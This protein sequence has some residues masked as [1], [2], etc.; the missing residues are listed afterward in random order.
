MHENDL[1][2][3]PEIAERVIRRQ[4]PQWNHERVQW[5]DTAGTVNVIVRI[6]ENMAARFRRQ[7]ADPKEVTEDLRQET[8]ALDELSAA[9]S[10]AV[11]TV[12]AIGEPSPEY[13]L[14]WSIQTWVPGEITTP[15]NVADSQ[16]FCDDLVALI[17]EFRQTDTQGRQFSGNGRGGELRSHDEWMETCFRRSEGLLDVPG[18]R[19]L[20]AQFREL[21][22]QEPDVMAH[23]DLI[24]GNLLTHGGRMA[25]LL[26][27]GSFGPADPAL[28][29]VSAWHLLDSPLHARLR[30]SLGCSELQWHRGAAWAFQQAMGLVWYYNN[31]NPVMR[32]LGR[33]TLTRIQSDPELVG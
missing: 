14:P 16:R 24:P 32:D 17:K 26:D 25:G 6:G 2:L 3:T 10:V 21:P 9:V 18:L 27:G 13:P 15:T 22:H 31:T 33:S 12:V 20:W 28:D 7:R 30:D 5:L 19:R 29:L 1:P 23:K 8:E 11:P 4:L